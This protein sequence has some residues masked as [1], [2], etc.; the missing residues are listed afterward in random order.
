MSSS[1]QV[2]IISMIAGASFVAADF[3]K[4][5]KVTG[6]NTAVLVAAVTDAP[7]GVI[8]EVPVGIGEEL[9]VAVIG[10]GGRGLVLAGGSIT[11]GQLVVPAADGTVTGVANTGALA[12]D[13]M[14]IGMAL[15]DA[16]S[17]EIF[18]VMFQSIGAPHSV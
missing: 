7:I 9:P 3:G 10:G 11:A 12:V 8:A 13:Q 4:L 15:A 6:A 17:G 18:E 14:A 1:E 16:S 5:V 2:K